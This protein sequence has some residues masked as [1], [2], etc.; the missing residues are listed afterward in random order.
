MKTPC[1]AALL[2]LVLYGQ[3][4]GKA[5]PTHAIA[6]LVLGQS[7]F[8]TDLSPVTSSFS[9]NF[10]CGVVIDPVS[11]KVF[12]AD[13]SNRRVLRYPSVASLSNGSGAEAV[14]G[15]ARFSTNTS[16]S[17]DLGM[18]RPRGMFF[19]RL[20]RLWVADET[21]NRVLMF[22]AASYRNTQAYP[23]RVYGQP[24]FTTNTSG[25]AINKMNGPEGVWVDSDDRLWVSEYFNNRVLWFDSISTK[26]SGADA[27]G[28]L[29]QATFDTSAAGSGSS[30]LQG[31]GGIA[32]SSQGALY[33]ACIDAQRVL[34]F[35]N[36]AA[37]G[38]GAGAN[39]VLGQPD[40][41]STTPGLS[42][43]QVA[44]AVGFWITPD[45]TL[46]VSDQNNN[47]VLRFDNASNK[48]N[49]AA[50]NGVV[51]Q[52]GFVTKDSVATN[53]SLLGIFFQ[54]FV[55]AGGNLWI[56]DSGNDRVLRFPPDVTRPKLK[57]TSN[58]PES[59]SGK[60]LTVKGTASDT[61]GISKV[62]YKV[63]SGSTRIATG[64]TSWE[65]KA[66]LKLGKNTITV[67]AVDSVGN[68]SVSK[69]LK[70]ERD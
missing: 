62:T 56:A 58:V 6:N 57:V 69:V 42:A 21:N 16:G 59:T 38:N 45:D 40:F 70:I 22:E 46:W 64:T 32:V 37:L 47:R 49:G 26:P 33:V 25:T 52:P 11:R 50:A 17:G 31:P 18:G 53:R 13:T 9:Q 2:G 24:D 67:T 39:A 14:F 43:T 55:D 41:A 5:V 34:R 23:D 48:T 35:N 28:V 36:A 7:D 63:N 44:R 8:T 1:I 12:V 30:G 27:N 15:Q 60:N 66:A 68:K 4:A 3:A 10:P 54:P 29:G 65:F 51:G 61:Y 20:G 19:D